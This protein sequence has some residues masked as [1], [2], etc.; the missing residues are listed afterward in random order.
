MPITV[1]YWN[2]KCNC[3]AIG[4]LLNGQLILYSWTSDTITLTMFIFNQVLPENVQISEMV[5]LLHFLHYHSL[6]TKC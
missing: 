5:K 3:F 2:L 4:V 1:P 6:H